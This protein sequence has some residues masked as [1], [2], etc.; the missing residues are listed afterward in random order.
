MF[1]RSG[2]VDGGTLSMGG[3]VET[4]EG[5]IDLSSCLWDKESG[6]GGTMPPEIAPAGD[7]RPEPV[8]GRRNQHRV[9][10]DHIVKDSNGQRDALGSGQPSLAPMTIVPL[11]DEFLKIDGER[12]PEAW[13]GYC[14]GTPIAAHPGEYHRRL[15]IPWDDVRGFG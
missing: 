9:F 4:L 2:E 7:E 8:Y 1:G 10:N 15:G 14:H 12:G 13:G 11:T 6:Q 5:E 3:N